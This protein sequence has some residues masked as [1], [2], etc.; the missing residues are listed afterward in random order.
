MF[1]KALCDLWASINLMPLSIFKN[2]GLGEARPTIVTL[3]LVDRSFKHLRGIIED[4]LIKVDKFIFSND[5]LILG[6]RDPNQTWETIL[7]NW[8]GSH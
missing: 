2:L 1:E 8:K 6:P 3:Q 5:F 7:G 4:V